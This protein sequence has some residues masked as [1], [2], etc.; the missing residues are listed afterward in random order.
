M[1]AIADAGAGFGRRVRLVAI[2]RRATRESL[3]T[4]WSPKRFARGAQQWNSTNHERVVLAT[5][6]WHRV[7][8]FQRE[9]LVRPDASRAS[10][11]PPV[12]TVHHHFER[13]AR[14]ARAAS[15]GVVLRRWRRGRWVRLEVRQHADRRRDARRV[16]ELELRQLDAIHRGCLRSIA[17]AAR[18]VRVLP[19]SIARDRSAEHCRRV[20]VVV[21]F[22]LPVTAM[23]WLPLAPRASRS[24]YDGNARLSAR[25]IAGLGR[26]T[27]AATT[28]TRAN[29]SSR[30][31]DVARRHALK[32]R[33]SRTPSDDPASDAYRA[34]PTSQQLAAATSLC[35]DYA[36]SPSPTSPSVD[37]RS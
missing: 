33:P 25:S 5:R 17:T 7:G 14:V 19:S 22:I 8:L 36:I 18:G 24:R 27:R 32:P 10:R 20:A 3:A 15:F 29:R 37:H 34:I 4:L 23:T 1:Q 2:S 28:M 12:V 16:V 26:D 13:S 30:A 11:S 9:S 6:T 35:H 21:V 31:T